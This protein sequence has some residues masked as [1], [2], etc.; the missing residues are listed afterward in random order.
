YFGLDKFLPWF[1]FV[2]DFGNIEK[3]S[4]ILL[5]KVGIWEEF[6]ASGWG[7]NGTSSLFQRSTVQNHKTGSHDI[8]FLYYPPKLLEMTKVAY[9][10]DY[11]MLDRLG[12]GDDTQPTAG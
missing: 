1:N 10:M 6:G 12:W 9:Q 4:R 3:H 7:P 8:Q 11:D 2:G 5:E